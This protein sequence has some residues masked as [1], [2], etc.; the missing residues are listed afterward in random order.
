V[1]E[2]RKNPRRE[3]RRTVRAVTVHERHPSANCLLLDISES[4]ARLHT[5]DGTVLPDSFLLVLDKGLEKWCRV[6]RRNR[7]EVGVKF[8]KAQRQKLQPAEKRAKPRVMV[9]RAV[10]AISLDDSSPA[11]DCVL[12]D[13]SQSGCKLQSRAIGMLPDEFML[14]LSDDL[15]RWCRVVRRLKN[16]V[17]ARFVNQR[18]APAAA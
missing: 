3:I 8:F 18:S 17:G 9:N 7:N 13:I 15:T 2:K 16:E 6:V 12:L 5:G 11:V 4:G 14:I 10:K 1:S